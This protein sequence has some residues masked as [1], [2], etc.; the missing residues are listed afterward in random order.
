VVPDTV[1]AAATV[2]ALL[3]AVDGEVFFGAVIAGAGPLLA[4]TVTPGNSVVLI[5]PSGFKK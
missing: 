3:I 5:E 1:G 4:V 2:L